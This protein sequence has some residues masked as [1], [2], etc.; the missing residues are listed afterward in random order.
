MNYNRIKLLSKYR[1]Q[2]M[3]LAMLLILIF[4]MGIDVS[5]INIIRSL[6]DIGDVGVDIFL[7]LS[8]IGLYFSYTKNSDKIHFYKKRILRILPTFIPVAIVWYSAFAL[9]FGGKIEDILLGVSTLSFWIKGS[10]TWWFISAILI[11]Y[12]CTPFYIDFFEKSPRKITICTVLV[13]IILGLLIRFTSLDNTLDYLLVFI[14]RIPIFIIGI[15]VGYLIV[16]KEEF[17]ISSTIIYISSIISLILSL[18][19]VNPQIIYIPFA[20]KYY[21]YIPLSEPP[22]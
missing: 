5:K 8:G 9:V 11:L 1:T 13:L 7:L 16:D 3:G 22:S 21:T 10:M 20:L 2:L 4:H 12:I 17:F 19:I 14:C 15:Y 6:K 18:L